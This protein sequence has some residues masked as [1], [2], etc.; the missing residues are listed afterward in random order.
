MIGRKYDSL[1]KYGWDLKTNR[2]SKIKVPGHFMTA[3]E[4][5]RR[6]KGGMGLIDHARNQPWETW[7][8]RYLYG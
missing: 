4:Y 2:I 6:N 7:K 8:G 5:A 3:M 1:W